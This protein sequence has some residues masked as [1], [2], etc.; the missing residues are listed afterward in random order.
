MSEVCQ[1]CRSGAPLPIDI[2]MAFQ[3]IVDIGTGRVFGYEAL[4]RGIDGRSAGDVLS[5]VSPD[6]IYKFDQTCRV[7]AIEL[8]GRLF[9]PDDGARLSINFMPNAV[10]EPD[11]CIRASLAAA[12]RV[13]FDPGRLMFEFTEDERMRDVA[14]VRRIV[15]AYR[16]RGFTTAIDDFGAGYAGLGLLADLRPDML[17]L[18]MALIRGIDGSTARQAIVAGVLQMAD[19]LGV[20]CIAEGIETAAELRTLHELGISLCQGYLLARPVTEAL[21]S[22]TIPI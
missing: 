3:P 9:S 17:K 10:Y 19:A 15:D 22:I 7:T 20:R 6:M 1:G 14:H 4:V 21:P 18:D 16:A 5:G 8:A 12:R 2:T 13:G 11:A